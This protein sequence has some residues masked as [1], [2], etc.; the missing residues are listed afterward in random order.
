MLRPMTDEQKPRSTNV[1]RD[2]CEAI[3]EL[4]DRE[5]RSFMGQVNY[6]LRLALA[7]QK[8]ER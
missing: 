4:A 2:L 5:R 8:P 7:D 6:L 3:Q 1:D